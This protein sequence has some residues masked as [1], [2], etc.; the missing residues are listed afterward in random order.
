MLSDNFKGPYGPG[1]TAPSGRRIFDV[2]QGRSGALRKIVKGS[3]R[4]MTD[5]ATIEGREKLIT[6]KYT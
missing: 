3:A 5:S 6:K 4:Q 2:G 1:V